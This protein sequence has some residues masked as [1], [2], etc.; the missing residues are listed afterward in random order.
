[1]N[2]SRTEIVPGSPVSVAYTRHSP[3]KLNLYAAQ[4]AMWW[5]ENIKGI[6]QPVG[7]VAHRGVAVEDGVVHGL[8]DLAASDEAC[9]SVAIARYEQL[10]VLSGDVRRDKYRADIPDMVAMALDEL[11]PLGTPT[12]TQGFIT[13]SPPELKLPIVGYFDFMWEDKGLIIDLKTTDRMPSEIKVGHARQVSFYA[14][15]D[16]VEGRLCYTT[17]KKVQTLQLENVRAHRQALLNIA[18]RVEAFMALSEDPEFGKTI[19][20]PDLD[21]FYWTNPAARQI[22]FEQWKI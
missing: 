7:A 5:L 15:S 13:W 21:S 19:F 16:N 12:A 3:S 22:A 11:R 4:P 6:K 14:S 2:Y 10:T 18:K 20:A 1:M 9:A 8:K 17:P